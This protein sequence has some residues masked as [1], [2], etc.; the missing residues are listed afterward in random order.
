MNQSLSARG[1][2]VRYPPGIK[3]Y[4][5][6]IPN[7]FLLTFHF[8][9]VTSEFWNVQPDTFFSSMR[10]F[11]GSTLIREHSYSRTSQRN[12]SKEE[13]QNLSKHNTAL[14]HK[15]RQVCPRRHTVTKAIMSVFLDFTTSLQEQDLKS[16]AGD[17]NSCSIISLGQWSGD[18][19]CWKMAGGGGS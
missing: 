16:S 6:G 18:S 3:L 19:F 4:I 12:L 11:M 13:Y 14:F 8:L 17:G 7:N 1:I 10:T 2:N 15:Y 9:G 5:F